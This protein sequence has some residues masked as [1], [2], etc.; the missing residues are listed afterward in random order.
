MNKAYYKGFKRI[1][2]DGVPVRMPKWYSELTPAGK[3]MIGTNRILSA[4]YG[5]GIGFKVE[6]VPYQAREAA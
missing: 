1:M 6:A 2:K 4:P 5:R 3:A